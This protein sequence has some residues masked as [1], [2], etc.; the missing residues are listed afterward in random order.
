MTRPQAVAATTSTPA[1]VVRRARAR[2]ACGGVAE[3]HPK[4]RVRALATKGDT[5]GQESDAKAV[6][7]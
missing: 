3:L 7:V 5:A 4:K 2:R 1:E 6:R